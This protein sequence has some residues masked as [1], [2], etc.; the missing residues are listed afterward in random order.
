MSL[1]I[2]EWADFI[3]PALKKPKAS[4]ITIGIFDGIH[5]GHTE[6]IRR[7]VASGKNPTVVTFREN[8][9][10][11]LE[12]QSYPGDI[13]TLNQRLALFEDLG[14]AE[15]ILIDFSENISKM[16]GREFI[17][18]LIDRGNLT[19]LVIGSNFRC[20][21]KLDT[22]AALI[23][24][25]NE[26]KGIPTEVVPPILYGTEAISSSRI[27]TAINQ[28]DLS[29]ATELLGRKVV[30]DLAPGISK[31]GYTKDRERII[32]D[33][34]G[35]LIPPSGRYR[36]LLQGVQ[37]SGSQVHQFWEDDI[38]IK[39]GKVLVPN[40]EYNTGIKIEFLSGPISAA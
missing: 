39:P 32:L 6:L 3:A 7:V 8:P 14:I 36:V 13:F 29:L 33:V 15:V 38:I 31:I 1:R 25:M 18:L 30:L 11:L 4:A 34:S 16:N 40:L 19:F 10:K 17:S 27:R 21:H 9:Q 28:G 24:N 23:K 20:G 2:F 5:L 12:P 22:D 37:N 35:R 26:A